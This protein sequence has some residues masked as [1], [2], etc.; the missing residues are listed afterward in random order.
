MLVLCSLSE[1]NECCCLNVAFAGTISERIMASRLI[2]SNQLLTH[3]LSVQ[4]SK[5]K[6]YATN[7]YAQSKLTLSPES[8]PSMPSY[9]VGAS[10][11]GK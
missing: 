2:Q 9:G 6:L 7:L 11:I 4:T 1:I 3:M 10:E 5:P 8:R